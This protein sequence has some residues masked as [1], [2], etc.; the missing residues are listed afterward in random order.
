MGNIPTLGVVMSSTARPTKEPG[1]VIVEM[2]GRASGSQIS[3][4]ARSSSRPS[5]LGRFEGI[6][7]TSHTYSTSYSSDA[8]APNCVNFV[9]LTDAQYGTQ[10]T[11]YS[12]GLTPEE[13]LVLKKTT[14]DGEAIPSSAAG[15]TGFGKRI[16][17]KNTLLF[18]SHLIYHAI[19]NTILF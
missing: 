1:R 19:T 18:E 4:N 5:W 3:L 13:I 2:A 14:S 9:R 8:S 17:W 6:L 15:S 12:C 7:I 10:F 11:S 16:P